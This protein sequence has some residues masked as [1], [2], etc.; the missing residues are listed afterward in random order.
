MLFSKNKLR[1]KSIGVFYLHLD[2]LSAIEANE[3]FTVVNISR[4]DKS[5]LA[6]ACPLSNIIPMG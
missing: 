6:R 2:K 1:A 3:I 4:L 5:S